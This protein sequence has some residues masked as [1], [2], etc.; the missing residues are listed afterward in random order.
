MKEDGTISKRGYNIAHFS[1]FVRP[2]YVRVDA[3]KNPD[4]NVYTSAY[5]GNNKVVIVAINKGASA[6]SQT[7]TLQNGKASKVT[8]WVTDASR[9]MAAGSSIKVKGGSFTAQLPA[10]SVTTFVGELAH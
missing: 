9:N 2:G 5:K 6:V 10:Q 1:K 3:T 7:F 4:T 8:P